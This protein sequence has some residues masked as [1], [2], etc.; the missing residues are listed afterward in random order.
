LEKLGRVRPGKPPGLGTYHTTT[1]R[2]GPNTRDAKDEEKRVERKVPKWGLQWGQTKTK[3]FGPRK[4][5]NLQGFRRG[6]EK[7]LAKN[8]KG[9]PA[10]N[11]VQKRLNWGLGPGM[12]GRKK[13]E[14]W[15]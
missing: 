9:K 4:Q 6:E 2:D 14:K 5:R 3:S 13:R 10:R 15:V 7:G 11:F 12:N 1:F 8:K